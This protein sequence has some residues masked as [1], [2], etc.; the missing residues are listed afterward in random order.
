MPTPPSEIDVDQRRRIVQE[1]HGWFGEVLQL[2]DETWFGS[3]P[4]GPHRAAVILD[5]LARLPEVREP[6]LRAIYD[7]GQPNSYY[8]FLTR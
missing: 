6:W 5:V 7:R 1:L 4:E 3:V 2:A 8:I